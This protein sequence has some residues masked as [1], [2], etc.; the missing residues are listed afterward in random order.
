MFVAVVA[1]GRYR[2]SSFHGT[3]T[4]IANSTD[5][6]DSFDRNR[7]RDSDRT[8]RHCNPAIVPHDTAT[9]PH[10]TATAPR[11]PLSEQV[12]TGFHSVPRRMAAPS[13][14]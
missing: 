9:V 12:P 5:T 2:P 14:C 3:A 4:A 7:V 8:A 10:D 1:V 13:G 6:N 11:Q